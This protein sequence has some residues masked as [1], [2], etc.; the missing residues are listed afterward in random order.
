MK[1]VGNNKNNHEGIVPT[2]PMM[3]VKR[4]LLLSDT[5]L[6]EMAG[7]YQKRNSS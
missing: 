1:F 3:L 5:L 7:G 2:T 4:I 6:Y